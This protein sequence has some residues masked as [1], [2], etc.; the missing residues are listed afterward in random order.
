[1]DNLGTRAR[2]G[3]LAA[4][5]ESPA[6]VGR[7]AGWAGAGDT[8]A[9][10]AAAVPPPPPQ[11]ASKDV[12]SVGRVESVSF[13]IMCSGS[14]WG[15]ARRQ[16]RRAQAYGT[17]SRPARPANRRSLSQGFGKSKDRNYASGEDIYKV[18]II[19][20]ILHFLALNL[21]RRRGDL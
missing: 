2:R 17:G 11:P 21:R 20:L 6:A 19:A 1:M 7:G 4:D 8:A 12:S 13:I 15:A 9:G 3:E 10:P 18:Q 16:C 14:G 5:S